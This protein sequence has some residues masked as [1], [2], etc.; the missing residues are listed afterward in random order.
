MT[1]KEQAYRAHA[2]LRA[3]GVTS[4]KR[5]HVHELLA[6]ALGYSSH[7]AFQHDAVW[8]DE[9][10]GQAGI[11]PD[12]GAILARCRELS[13]PADMG[14][15]VVG[16]LP[17]FLQNSG[18]A[19]VRFD[20]LIAAVE[21][22]EDDPDWREWVWT[23][24]VES[25]EDHLGTSA[26]LS[27]YFQQQ[28]SLLEGLEA[29]AKR[30]VPTAHLAI[31]KLLDAAVLL[32]RVEGEVGAPMDAW[33]SPFV[34]FAEIEAD[35]PR[36]TDKFRHHLLEAARGGDIRALMETAER[37]R[38]PEVL[39]RAPSSDMHPLRMVEIAYL[40]EDEEKVRYWLTV[41]ARE[42]DVD[43]MRELIIEYDETNEQAWV[44]MYLSCLLD[45]DLSQDRY[46]AIHENGT[47]YDDDIGGNAYVGGDGG[48]RLDPLPSRVDAV[49]RQVAEELFAQIKPLATRCIA[50]IRQPL[51]GP[52]LIQR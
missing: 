16:E 24:V 14:P 9:P 17:G 27:V 8:Y 28:R 19:P 41:A 11:E 13:L 10:F 6:A 52:T 18:L 21:G 31:A 44:W 32:H 20:E 43:S 50:T 34:S 7:A 30:G 36:V 37:Y 12:C 46:E 22:Y 1:I 15:R 23:C 35:E 47:P 3:R 33:T 42:G 48:I 38:D 2:F 49:A 39:E 45:E 29:A 26:P 4:L 25:M 5:S 40:H 51:A